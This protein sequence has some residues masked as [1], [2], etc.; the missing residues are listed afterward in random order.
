M[1]EQVDQVYLTEAKSLIEKNK[2]LVVS[3]TWCPDCHYAKKVFAGLNSNP[4]YVELDKLDHGKELQAAF[5]QLT[6]QNTVPNVFIA[7]E[8][9]GTENDIKRLLESGELQKKLSDAG[10]ISA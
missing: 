6:N 8:H 5:L 1:A 2:F 9:I 7:R 4:V 3:K 10:L